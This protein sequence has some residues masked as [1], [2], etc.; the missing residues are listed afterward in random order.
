MFLTTLLWISCA[1]LVVSKRA[2]CFSKVWAVWL[3]LFRCSQGTESLTPSVFQSIM[4]SDNAGEIKREEENSGIS[5]NIIRDDSAQDEE[6]EQEQI[7]NTNS[8]T[9]SIQNEQPPYQQE[10]EKFRNT[11]SGIEYA[12]RSDSS[13]VN[14]LK[15]ATEVCQEAMR[16]RENTRDGAELSSLDEPIEDAPAKS[17][18]VLRSSMPR[19]VL[20]LL[21]RSDLLPS[22]RTT[23][24]DF[25]TFY[26]DVC[27]SLG[28]PEDHT[29]LIHALSRV[30]VHSC[31]YY[32][33]SKRDYYERLKKEN[34]IEENRASVVEGTVGANQALSYQ[35]VRTDVAVSPVYAQLLEYF[36]KNNGFKLLLQLL[37]KSPQLNSIKNVLRVVVNMKSYIQLNYLNE[38]L[39]KVQQEIF[40]QLLE[41]ARNEFKK[42]EKQ[43]VAEIGDMLHSMLSLIWTTHKLEESIEIF[44]LDVSLLNL[45]STNLER[46]LRGIKFIRK[47]VARA[48]MNRDDKTFLGSLWKAA[49]NATVNAMNNGGSTT[50]QKKEERPIDPKLVMDWLKDKDVVG[51]ICRTTH[52]EVIKQSLSIL[53]F[54]AKMNQMDLQYFAV[55]YDSILGKHE[56]VKNTIL[57]SIIQVVP[58][59]SNENMYNFFEHVKAKTLIDDYD[60]ETIEFLHSYSDIALSRPITP[61]NVERVNWYGLPLL[62]QYISET[63]RIPYKPI[64][65]TKAITKIVELLQK[66]EC[67]NQRFYYMDLFIDNIR[68]M[69]SVPDSLIILARIIAT[70]FKTSKRKKPSVSMVIE[71]LAQKHNLLG[72]V[73]QEIV[74][75]KTHLVDTFII[76]P[77]T[78]MTSTA[79]GGRAGSHRISHMEHVS[80]RLEF[81]HFVLSNSALTLAA[82]EADILWD[83]LVSRSVSSV[84]REKVYLWF[85]HGTKTN[86]TP[87]GSLFGKAMTSEQIQLTSLGD[88]AVV[89]GSNAAITESVIEHLFLGKMLGMSTT[90]LSR[91]GYHLFDLS[92][93][94]VNLRSGKIKKVGGRDILLLN[95]IN[96][97]KSSPLIQRTPSTN[98]AITRENTFPAHP[99]QGDSYLLIAEGFTGSN[100]LWN[101]ALEAEDASISQAAMRRLNSFHQYIHGESLKPRAVK[102]REDYIAT[103]IKHLE[104]ATKAMEG[105][106]GKNGRRRSEMII[107]RCLTLLTQLVEEYEERGRKRVQGKEVMQKGEGRQLTLFIKAERGMAPIVQMMS[108]ETVLA[109]KYKVGTMIGVPGRSLRICTHDREL[110]E[111]GKTLGD[112]R[113]SDRQTLIARKRTLDPNLPRRT[114]GLFSGLSFTSALGFTPMI[115]TYPVSEK[116]KEEKEEATY[117]EAPVEA[118]VGESI[119]HM[120]GGLLG[121]NVPLPIPPSTPSQ[122][123]PTPSSSNVLHRSTHAMSETKGAQWVEPQKGSPGQILERYFDV[124][125]RVL[126]Y[127]DKMG[128]MAWKLLSQIKINGQLLLQMKNLG[129]DPLRWEELIDTQHST[130]KMIYSLQIIH[131]LITHPSLSDSIDPNHRPFEPINPETWRRTFIKKGGLNHLVSILMRPC[132]DPPGRNRFYSLLLSII[133][134][135]SIDHLQTPSSDR[136]SL[137]SPKGSHTF[138]D[139]TF[140]STIDSETLVMRLLEIS[141]DAACTT[142]EDVA[143]ATSAVQQSL[144]MLIA[145]VFSG[146]DILDY[147]YQWN[148]L[149]EWLLC[150]VLTPAEKQ[151]REGSTRLVLVLCSK[152]IHTESRKSM[153]QEMGET[154]TSLFMKILLSYLPM[155]E[156]YPYN[157]EQYFIL[158][159]KLLRSHVENTF[160]LPIK[161]DI[162]WDQLLQKMYHQI[163]KHPVLESSSS[164]PPDRVIIGILEFLRVFLMKF[165]HL[166]ESSTCTLIT[167]EVFQNCLFSVTAETPRGVNG[168]RA[169]RCQTEE[170]RNAAF[171]LLSEIV[172][173][174]VENMNTLCRLL[175]DQLDHLSLKDDWSCAPV[176]IEK[177]EYGYVGLQNLG[178]TCYLN[179]L[180]QQ[181]NFIPEFKKP[182]LSVDLKAAQ[183]QD[184]E[185]TLLYQIQ[186]LFSHLQDSAKKYYNPVQLCTTLKDYEGRAINTSVQMDCNEFS[187]MLFDHL[188]SSLKGTHQ[189]H[190]LKNVFSGTL[191]NQLICKECPH[192]SERDEPFYTLSVE[193]SRQ[194]DINQSLK[195]FIKGEMLVDDNKYF[196][197]KCN[198]AVE[199]LKRCV[200]KD[201]PNMLL[202]HLKRFEFDYEKMKHIKLNDRCEFPMVLDMEPYTKEG[203]ASAEQ[204]DGTTRQEM[205]ENDVGRET[206]DRVPSYY[207]YEL[208][209][210]V[211]HSGTADF[212]HYYSFIK[213][214][215][216]EREE[217]RKER[218]EERREREEERRDKWYEFNDVTITPFDPDDIPNHCF[219]GQ[220]EYNDVDRFTGK[221]NSNV[222]VKSY[223]AYILVYQRKESHSEESPKEE[224]IEKEDMDQRSEKETLAEKELMVGEGKLESASYHPLLAQGNQMI[225]AEGGRSRIVNSN[226]NLIIKLSAALKDHNAKLSMSQKEETKEEMETE[227]K[228]QVMEIIHKDN[229]LFLL[230]KSVICRDYFSFIWSIVNICT[231]KM[232]DGQC[233]ISHPLMS[234]DMNNLPPNDPFLQATQFGTLFLF[235][236]YAHARDKPMFDVWVKQLTK[237]YQSSHQASE[238]LIDSLTSNKNM[239]KQLFIT[240]PFDNIRVAFTHI[241]TAAITSIDRTFPPPDGDHIYNPPKDTSLYRFMTFLLSTRM[242][243]SVRRQSRNCTQYFLLLENIASLG[244]SWRKEMLD[245]EVISQLIEFSS[246]GG[247]YVCK[248]ERANTLPVRLV[249]ANMVHI[250]ELCSLLFRSCEG[251]FLS[252]REENKRVIAPTLLPPGGSSFSMSEKDIK[253]L[254]DKMFLG[255]MTRESTDMD[256]V[257]DIAIH[258]CYEDRKCTKQWVMIF[259]E[260][261]IILVPDTYKTWFKLLNNLLEI[262]DTLVN[263]RLDLILVSCLQLVETN[264]RKKELT[265]AFTGYLVRLAERNDMAKVWLFKHKEPLNKLVR[266]LLK[267]VTAAPDISFVSFAT[268]LFTN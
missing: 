241:V 23:C 108:T 124:L 260:S 2:E 49:T 168:S 185:K 123:T 121:I 8:T 126:N 195:S 192:S 29:E 230:E 27:L 129:G 150:T 15:S 82:E 199:T 46:K 252:E 183:G 59:L 42:E 164:G 119:R 99:Q 101:I 31:G 12:L 5:D 251:P 105:E 216:K 155:V 48:Q 43:I 1:E 151:I 83:A 143:D 125:Y 225:V 39:P 157:C 6:Q 165:P 228:N 51:C 4:S 250:L 56:S 62:A 178:A 32:H 247:E 86:T 200:I 179:S 80:I 52:P 240:C 242:L 67:H 181:L 26:L 159:V 160:I 209:G 58:Y 156:K 122:P 268:L 208:V 103:C 186:L 153:S 107:Q 259:R 210:V 142:G 249:E 166:K 236:V 3:K 75:Y 206:E 152:D 256:V 55:L 266:L 70:Y 162:D 218:E 114:N 93:I 38:Y 194:K 229:A 11:C 113:I 87:N 28:L 201:L 263:W 136:S 16:I 50:Q 173:D 78:L 170:S 238:W 81:L 47:V 176:E 212:G 120:L 117:D 85:Q 109:L 169:P 222:R 207:Q 154:A 217:E 53:I 128:E 68:L 137:L 223:N 18:Y 21:Q 22:L 79:S 226:E 40:H 235:Q 264:Q 9:V 253:S 131:L 135:L 189:E 14:Y 19:M 88:P 204:A 193:I 171:N 20:S 191:C 90:S 261:F 73:I 91:A 245:R 203:V 111:E 25:F 57:T 187:N 138:K 148:Q 248:G 104:T 97:G 147:F 161:E 267:G 198:R 146:Q 188:E 133:N 63:E 197:D 140:L 102:L 190:L 158:L 224:D 144:T 34:A 139:P 134:L 233:I 45:M 163:A 44:N 141:L 13:L 112:F 211:V 64:V 7:K 174:S 95:N 127:S 180:V 221:T 106:E 65:I 96:A 118:L 17:D 255:R 234:S 182:L 265:E 36:A 130:F 37:E 35:Y 98:N 202:L 205:G 71:Q 24:N 69:R 232:D 74:V 54:A 172:T 246:G 76:P 258:A 175:R 33:P 167:Q 239:L 219:G 215:G 231:H 145:C 30:F 89:T 254:L 214:R 61:N 72:L 115:N 227:R 110:K 237:V 184:I 60:N 262:K 10:I 77:E 100:E 94:I 41:M 132:I 220:E 243:K 196:C 213:E 84:E 244:P 92:C 149:N 66:P 116:K 257:R 177:S